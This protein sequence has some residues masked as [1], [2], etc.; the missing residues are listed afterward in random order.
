MTSE[1]TDST[2]NEEAI[3]SEQP[4]AASPGP[5]FERKPRR[6]WRSGWTLAFLLLVVLIVLTGLYRYFIL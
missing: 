1:R 6:G 5:V 3:P 2:V 4:I